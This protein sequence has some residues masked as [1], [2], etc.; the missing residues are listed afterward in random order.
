MPPILNGKRIILGVS[1]GIACYKAVILASRLTQANAQVDV[2][3]TEA[4]TKFV[5]PVTF[6]AI[7]QRAVS[8]DTFESWTD[9]GRLRSGHITLAHAADL[10]IV[11]P[12]T[13]QTI[14]RLALGLTDEL[15][16][17]TALSYKG[18]MLIAPAMETNMWEH[19]ATQQHADTLR[20][21]H[22]DFAGPASGRLASGEHGAGR[23]VEPDEIF[24][25]ACRVLGRGGPLT[26][27]RV[28]IT[29]GGTR[30][31]IDPVRFVGNHSTGKMGAALARAARDLGADTVLIHA[32]LSVT[33][34][35]GVTRVPVTTAQQMHDAVM[36][37]LPSTDVLIGSA[38]VADY[39]PVHSEDK[40]IKKLPGEQTIL[41][42]RTPDIL[43]AVGELRVANPGQPRLVVGFAAETDDLEAN[44][45]GKLERKN[46]DMIVLND[47]T[48]PDAGFAVDTNR[49]IIFERGG[50]REDWPLMSKE[51][52]AQAILQ[53]IAARL[54][55]QNW[56][57]R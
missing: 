10:F 9:T 6:Q 27:V 26:G 37:Y 39:R 51:E 17:L 22:V 50:N 15:L 23:M 45:L 14:A 4:A 56:K 20:S 24:E 5:A 35:G 42:E 25:Q 36:E 46:L 1:G 52:V 3:M 11:A 44:A 19:P 31:P 29:A 38:A 34:P 54:G 16:T 18:P 28:V 12:A 55:R 53:R 43:K 49:V 57:K 8:T 2:I 30:E 7:T 40:K 21:W 33:A 32:P 48:A 41:L 47:V 13:A